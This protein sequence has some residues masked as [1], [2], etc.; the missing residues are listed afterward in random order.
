MFAIGRDDKF[1]FTTRFNAV[2]FHQSPYAFF[3][4][5]HTRGLQLAPYLWPPIFSFTVSMYR[6]DVHQQRFIIDPLIGQR[7][8]ICAT[9]H[10]SFK[11][12]AATNL[13]YI[14]LQGDR[15]MIFVPLYPCVLHVDS[16]AKYAVDF[17]NMSR[18][19][20]TRTSSA[21]KR[22]NSICSG[23]TG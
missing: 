17:F 12:T 20:L 19:I 18:S 4:N 15:P 2:F 10:L 16:R 21:L 3:L 11:V 1:T 23:L 9:T 5:P 7:W 8:V 14:A 6:F 13:Q 22:A